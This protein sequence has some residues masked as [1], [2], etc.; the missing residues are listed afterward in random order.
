M[1][2][3]TLSVNEKMKLFYQLTNVPVHL[4]SDNEHIFSF[5][6]LGSNFQKQFDWFI[7]IV[8][9]SLK[10]QS[11]DIFLN[12]SNTL[13]EIFLVTKLQIHNDN[14]YV[15]CGPYILA[16][17]HEEFINKLILKRKA[18]LEEK[19]ELIQSFS[20]TK[21]LDEKDN[22][23]YKQL[24]NELFVY[25]GTNSPNKENTLSEKFYIH[26]LENKEKWYSHPPYYIEQKLLVK[27]KEGNVKEAE[28]MVQNLNT[29]H[30]A[31]LSKN[32]IR[33]FKNSLICRCTL[34]TRA[35]I[36]GGVDSETAFTLSD[37]YINEIEDL[38]DIQG[39]YHLDIKMIGEFTKLIKNRINRMYSPL[40]QSAIKIVS[41]SISERITVNSIA[42]EIPTN[43][44]YLSQIFK[45]EVGISL[46]A[47]INQSKV[48][49]AKYFLSFTESTLADISNFLQFSS[50]SHFTS[51]FKTHV[52]M[53]PLAYR[54][55]YKY[56]RNV[57]Q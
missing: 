3:L 46:N 33:S 2:Q 31:I 4:F 18:S 1:K 17:S 23:L 8:I 13:E 30:D 5:A 10:T 51:T 40:V 26:R 25:L 53:T 27:I 43:S 19:D 6:P 52:G 11:S 9:D 35:V 47:Y 22:F 20:Y 45:K 56:S 12:L 15:L 48:E 32:S 54:K 21:L 55:N 38:Y 44:N 57:L 39:L 41:S 37:L 50:Q 24:F 36:E 16:Q 7:D 28:N 34:Y 14:Y 29:Y 42:N 49:E